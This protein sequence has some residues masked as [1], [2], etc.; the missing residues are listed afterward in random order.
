MAIVGGTVSF[1]TIT[2]EA[3]PEFPTESASEAANVTSPSDKLDRSTTKLK[4]GELAVL[5]IGFS[6]GI[7]TLFPSVTMT[8]TVLPFSEQLPLMLNED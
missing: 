2:E 4:L 1:F 6:V 5:Q 3:E 8:A 7:A